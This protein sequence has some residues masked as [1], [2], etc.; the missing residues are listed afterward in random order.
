MQGNACD[1]GAV[2]CD[3]V[4]VLMPAA[5]R[6]AQSRSSLGCAVLY[7]VCTPSSFTTL[8]NPRLLPRNLRI[9]YQPRVPY[10][11]FRRAASLGYMPSATRQPRRLRVFTVC[12]QC[13]DIDSHEEC[14]ATR[15]LT[16][17]TS[18]TLKQGHGDSYSGELGPTPQQPPP[19]LTRK[20][21]RLL[22]SRFS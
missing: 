15:A 7:T 6:F 22:A 21:R 17:L 19:P 10:S 12:T 5:L 18:T 9:D 14:V 8:A 11:M 16:L 2:L 3:F 4:S 1:P 13:S 20:M